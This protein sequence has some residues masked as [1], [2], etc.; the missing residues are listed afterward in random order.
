VCAMPFGALEVLT[1]EVTAIQ[2][3]LL[4]ML[5]AGIVYES[6]LLMLRETMTAGAISAA[7]CL[8]L[9]PTRASDGPGGF[10]LLVGRPSPYR[11]RGRVVWLC[12]RRD[13]RKL[14]QV[15]KPAPHFHRLIAEARTDPILR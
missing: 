7:R 15:K 9:L 12:A 1:P 3:D 5:S 11:A 10:A 6:S 4:Q 14:I 13:A 8:V 2:R